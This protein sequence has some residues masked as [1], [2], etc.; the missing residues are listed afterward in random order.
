MFELGL[1]KLTINESIN[2]LFILTIK[3]IF[4]D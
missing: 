4:N 3:I 1:R 2:R